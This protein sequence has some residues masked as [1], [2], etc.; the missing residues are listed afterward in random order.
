MDDI[1]VHSAVLQAKSFITARIVGQTL[2]KNALELNSNKSTLCKSETAYLGFIAFAESLKPNPAKMKLIR[3]Y[4]VPRDCKAVQLFLGGG[5]YYRRFLQN[6][7]RRA[8]PLQRLVSQDVTLVRE[9]EQQ[10]ACKNIK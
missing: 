5:S 4:S 10:A 9:N 1:V 2:Q 7:A 8:E 3:I 6:Y